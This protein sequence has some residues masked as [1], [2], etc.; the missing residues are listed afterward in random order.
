MDTDRDGT[1]K[2]L[3]LALVLILPGTAIAEPLREV[4][5]HAL[6]LAFEDTFDAPG[7]D[8]TGKGT[9]WV[10]WFY[11]FNTRTLKGN[12]ELERY[13]D[14]ADLAAHNLS[15]EH[16]PFSY[17]AGI[18]TLTATRIPPAMAARVPLIKGAPPAQYFSG[19]ISS[20]RIFAQ[21][22]GYF[23]ARVR[24]PGTPGTWPAFWLLPKSGG[25]PPEIDV[26]EVI[27]QEPRRVHQNV[28]RADKSSAH[29]FVDLD[30]TSTDW[31]SY[32]LLWTKD[33]LVWF[34]DGTETKRE[35]NTIHEDMYMILNLAVGGRWPGTPPPEAPFPARMEIDA[36]H[37]YALANAS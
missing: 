14:R 13:T 34:I 29:T 4:G 7:I 11:T 15:P 37:V 32:G 21:T 19:M 20:E 3:L 6:K 33:A 5:G 17:A 22:Y 1:M 9:G 36:V 31:H 18:L 30:G 24:L 23:E 26:F 10:P 16:D 27:G 28:I 12:Q 35:A 25:W 2:A 8:T